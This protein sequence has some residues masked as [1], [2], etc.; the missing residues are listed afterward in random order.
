MSAESTS[1]TEHAALRLGQRVPFALHTIGGK[2]PDGTPVSL[3]AWTFECPP[4]RRVVESYLT[5]TVLNACAGKTKLRTEAVDE[6]VR[7]DINPKMD[8]DYHI[9]VCEIG[10][11]F[12]PRSFDVVV[13]DP[14]FSQKQ[15]DE[16][17]DSAHATDMGQARKELRDL[18]KVGGT[19]VE[20][21][22]DMWGAADFF[23][24][25]DRDDKLLFRRGIPNRPPV[26]M[27]V[28]TKRQRTLA[29]NATET[30][31]A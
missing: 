12:E 27:T 5:G 10:H 29:D 11:H 26:F 25:W 23:K 22:F 28:D 24:G 19:I 16:H 3:G 7:N 21:G 2:H 13:F 15:A 6:I 18:T 14:P 1:E 17:Y 31:D 30:E 20:L 9:D 8:A 4:V